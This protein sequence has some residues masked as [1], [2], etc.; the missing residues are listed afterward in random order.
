MKIL[1]NIHDFSYLS[2]IFVVL[3][4]SIYS[5]NMDCLDE[6][7]N[8]VYHLGKFIKWNDFSLNEK[9]FCIQCARL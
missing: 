2:F 7:R 1:F 8:I 5:F 4:R 9:N 6:F 3:E